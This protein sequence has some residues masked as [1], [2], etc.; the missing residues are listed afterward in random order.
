MAGALFTAFAGVSYHAH[1][2]EVEVDPDTGKVTVTR[3][4][5]VQDVGRIVNPQM[6]EGQVHGG[7]LQ[8]VGY[9]LYEELRLQD[10]R[11]LDDNLENYRLP[12]AFEAPPIE[13]SLMEVPCNYGPF[14]AKGAAEPPI[15]PVAAAIASA[16]S[17]AIGQPIRS[18]PVTPFEVL[19]LLRNA[20]DGARGRQDREER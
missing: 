7:V 14:G 9:A 4:I 17:D 16:V 11:V 1:L 12:T 6:I 2:A 13:V 15:V 18:L 3:Y 8:G 20:G 10:G 19:K 5:V